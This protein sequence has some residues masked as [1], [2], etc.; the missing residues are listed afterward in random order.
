MVMRGTM[1]TGRQW[2]P[3]DNSNCN[4]AGASNFW[5]V[6]QSESDVLPPY[7]IAPE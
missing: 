6:N 5:A 3:S 2:V 4:I 1:V 7:S